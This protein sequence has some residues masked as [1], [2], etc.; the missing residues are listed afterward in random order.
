MELP[1]LAGQAERDRLDVGEGREIQRIVAE[2][3]SSIRGTLTPDR[4][5][6][7]AEQFAKRTETFQRIQLQ[8]QI[9]A[10]LGA[11]IF[12]A[13][14]GLAALIDG[15]ATENAA[16]I[17]SIPETLLGRVERLTTR[18]VQRA[19]PSRELAKSIEA[20]LGIAR[21]RARTIAR[22]QIG[23]L[24]GQVNAQRQKA[25]G[26]DRFIWRTSNDERVREEHAARNGNVYKYS[27]PPAGELPGEPINCRCY[28]EPVLTD[29]TDQ[30]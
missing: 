7:L 16:L 24:Y 11:D 9:R 18:G 15:F 19:M 13:D 25:I 14:N 6:R 27:D 5:E 4:L 26:V 30:V 17:K 28:A 20:E 1:R 10:G 2:I 21:N 3:A 23:S 8:K 22:D 12:L 29:I